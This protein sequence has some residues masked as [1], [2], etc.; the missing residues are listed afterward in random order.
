MQLHQKLQGLLDQ[1]DAESPRV[2]EELRAMLAQYPMEFRTWAVAWIR[3]GGRGSQAHLLLRLLHQENLLR[4][5]LVNPGAIPFRSRGGFPAGGSI[6]QRLWRSAIRA[7]A[8]TG[9][10]CSSRWRPIRNE[11]ACRIVVA[12]RRGRPA[13]SAWSSCR[14][15][16]AGQWG[17]CR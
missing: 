6:F 2:H 13:H 15:G 11:Q 9:K 5:L 8:A 14:N 12:S 17:N 4:S 16:I 7:I 3:N 10:L 1:P